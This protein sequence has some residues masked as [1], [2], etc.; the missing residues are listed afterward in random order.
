VPQQD[1]KGQLLQPQVGTDE[2]ERGPGR[3]QSLGTKGGKWKA[4]DRERQTDRERECRAS[5]E[6]QDQFG[7]SIV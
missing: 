1:D 7:L 5:Q 4:K 2:E 6:I 3:R